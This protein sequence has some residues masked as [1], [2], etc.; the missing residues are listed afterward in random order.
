MARSLAERRLPRAPHTPRAACRAAAWLCALHLAVCLA[1]C[2]TPPGI[3]QH[4]YWSESTLY[5][6]P[7]SAAWFGSSRPPLHTTA[8]RQLI[9]S[10]PNS[11]TPPLPCSMAPLSSLPSP[12]DTLRVRDGYRWDKRAVLV[13]AATL[14]KK[15][16]QMFKRRRVWGQRVRSVPRR[17]ARATNRR[18]HER[19]K[20]R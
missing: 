20:K 17:M 9:Y 8:C 13:V 4:P 14:Q 1:P 10:I 12:P 11:L 5:T 3:L 2:P 7:L 18:W 6:V 16:Y 15:K 19:R